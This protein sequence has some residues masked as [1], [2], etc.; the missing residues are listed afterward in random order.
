MAE[1]DHW[2]APDPMGDATERA[3]IRA[4]MP[5]DE[6]AAVAW[7]VARIH[8]LA[9]SGKRR[10]ANRWQWRKLDH[11]GIELAMARGFDAAVVAHFPLGYRLPAPVPLPASV[12]PAVPLRRHARVRY[13]KD[14]QALAAFLVEFVGKLRTADG[15]RVASLSDWRIAHQSSYVKALSTGL[16]RAVCD[17]LELK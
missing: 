12:G 17:K 14:Q 11:D 7:M 4:A 5:K 9:V 10:I 13:P 1:R 3:R 8:S 15:R 16:Q 2:Q 6:T